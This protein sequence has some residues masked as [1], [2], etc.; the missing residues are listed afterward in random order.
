MPK[1]DEGGTSLATVADRPGA[2]GIVD[3]DATA[4]MP[5]GHIPGADVP[6]RTVAQRPPRTFPTPPT[7]ADHPEPANFT[8]TTAADAL[9]NEE[10]DRTR[11]FI[12]L[13]WAISVGAIGVV[14]LLP[15]PMPM[16]IAMVVAMLFGIVVSFGYHQRFADPAKYSGEA[17]QKLA[18]MSCINAHV[19][20][21]FFG[22]FTMCPLIV[23]I[24]FHFLGRT[25]AARAGKVVVIV[26]CI[27]YALI[28]GAIVAGL[29]DDPG[30]FATP[31]PLGHVT[32][33]IGAGFVLAVYGLAFITGRVFRGQS[34]IAIDELARATRV[35]SQREA[36][37]AELRADLERAL[38]I[39]GPGRYTDQT[40][41]AFKLG[42]V[43]GRGA[44][45]E[46]YEAVHTTTSEPA[47]VK[48]LRRELLSDAT[49]VARFLREA[50]ASG[51]LA[52]PYV[53][54]VLDASSDD[55]ALP[56]LAMER[57]HGATLAELLR[58]ESKL[59][60]ATVIEV[61]RH[62][63]AGIDA[64]AAAGIV[65]RDLK[66]QNLFKTNDGV[67]KILDFGVATLGEEASNLTQGGVVGTPS[68][69]APEQA[70]GKRVD[71]RAD[72]YAIAAVAYRCL[73]GRHPYSGTDT[74]T[75]LYAVV[76]KMPLRPSSIAEL[77]SDVDACL[78]VALAKNPDDRFATGAA[79]AAALEAALDGSL[80][81]ALRK[82]AAALLR[83][84]PWEEPS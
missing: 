63:G 7:A 34:L 81:P 71:G 62:A 3:P 46:V 40:V 31:R 6:T 82:R 60:G 13:G 16:R 76:H 14:P 49:T 75:L 80:D 47:A 77:H 73:T 84:L 20:V 67:W 66:P 19:A 53:V 29:F 42:V 22:V 58:R 33:A 21:L 25:E 15:S 5:E 12:R 61:V 48:L 65:H 74:P 28:S 45:G 44:M 1:D 64:A 68:Y 70:Q 18:M 30:V 79:F 17:L 10:I 43:L 35:T 41:G 37:M 59:A 56:Y 57:L 52:S 8:L 32:Q 23:V 9:H 72:G 24:G 50:K 78:A 11:L 27:C 54:R 55:A 83:K 38:R 39:G 36:L 26:G 2:K 4:D 51:A 69:M